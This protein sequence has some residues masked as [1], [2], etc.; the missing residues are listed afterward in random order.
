MQTQHVTRKQTR[1][2]NTRRTIIKPNSVH[3]HSIPV[4]IGRAQ[5]KAPEGGGRRCVTDNTLD[6]GGGGG[7]CARNSRQH[8]PGSAWLD[9]GYNMMINRQT[10]VA[11]CGNAA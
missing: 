1:A 8:E 3:T 9:R 6:G 4:H 5:P 2:D 7:A 10:R 11:G